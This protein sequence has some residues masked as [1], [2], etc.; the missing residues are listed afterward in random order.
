MNEYPNKFTLGQINKYFGEY[1][2]ILVYYKNS[3]VH[4]VSESRGGGPLS[5]LY[6]IIVPMC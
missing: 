2:I 3:P 6:I 4:T 1:N 5:L